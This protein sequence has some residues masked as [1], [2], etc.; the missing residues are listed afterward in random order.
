MSENIVCSSLSQLCVCLG[1]L[2]FLNL[3]LRSESAP[4]I[5][6]IVAA[7]LPPFT[8]S[9]TKA[10]LLFRLTQIAVSRCEARATLEERFLQES[11]VYTSS[12]EA[13]EAN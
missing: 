12:S 7:V 9:R 10:F 6:P 11:L 1:S 5:S 13:L 4:P 2:G 8:I 3:A